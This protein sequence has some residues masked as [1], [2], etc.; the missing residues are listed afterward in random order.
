M[1]PN[2]SEV[3][4]DRVHRFDVAQNQFLTDGATI[5]IP[6]DD[7]VQTI[8]RDSLIYVVTGWSNTGNV[9]DVQVYD[10]HTDSWA[11]G[12][13]TPNNNNYKCFGASGEIIGDTLYFY[14]GAAGFSFGARSQLRKGYINPI[15]PTDVTWFVV[16]P[17]PAIKAYR[18]AAG[19][20]NG[21][22]H[23][24]GGSSV[25]YNYNG[26]AYNGSGP[27]APSEQVVSYNP[28]SGD[29]TSEMLAGLP[30]DLRGIGNGSSTEKYLVGGIGEGLESQ[31]TILRLTYSGTLA[32]DRVIKTERQFAYPNPTSGRIRLAQTGVLSIYDLAGKLVLTS[33]SHD[34]TIDLRSLPNGV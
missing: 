2:G 23:W 27:V 30:M 28:V 34:E 14:G 10:T 31:S 29:L 33:Q 24:I 11:F 8:Y 21:A 26:I 4:S 13:E 19:L 22:V 32:I 18:S 3:S 15:D 6:I 5:P 9:P 20:T 7:H 1:L 16:D 25:T 12:T 17:N